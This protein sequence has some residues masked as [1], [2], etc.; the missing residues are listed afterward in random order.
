MNVDELCDDL[1]AERSD[2][3]ALVE[4]LDEGGWRQPT[5]APGWSILDQLTH[6]AWFDDAARQAIDD[7]D[8]FR[9]HR[10]AVLADVDGF[11]ARVAQA[12]RHRSGA[13]V[14]DWLRRAGDQLLASASAADPDVR[15]PWYGPDMSVGSN[16]TARIMETWAH[17]QDVADA[18]GVT[19]QPTDRLRHVAFIGWRSLPNSF[20][21]HRRPVPTEPVRVE[22]D[23]VTLGPAEATNVVQGP[24]LDFC[25]V[26]TQRR[27]PDDTRLT[28]EGDV[29]RE[30]M[31]IAQ[32][33]A[34]PPGVGRRPGQFTQQGRST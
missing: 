29:A 21:A 19:R 12:N 11:V 17:G 30:W 8:G 24:L 6:L 28:A 13:E 9:A 31:R 18:L 3:L 15:I 32:A 33:F 25:L 4:S 14:Q 7:P 16:V 26:V 22:L 23:G 1:R 5:P 20:H 34:G 27:H 10:P 2:L